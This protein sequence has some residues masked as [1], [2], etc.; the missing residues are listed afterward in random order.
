MDLQFSMFDKNFNS[1]S[2]ISRFVHRLETVDKSKVAKVKVVAQ[3]K[4]GTQTETFTLKKPET[5][6]KMFYFTKP[7][8]ISCNRD[9][10]FDA[11]K[12]LLKISGNVGDSCTVSY[13]WQ[14]V[15]LNFVQIAAGF[16]L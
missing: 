16:G 15:P 14:G 12:N 6:L 2:W 5:V 9:F 13:D 3:V 11:K 8:T 1:G 7:E 4:Q 10:I